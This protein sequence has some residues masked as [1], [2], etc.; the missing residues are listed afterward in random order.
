M[1]EVKAMSKLPPTIA[2][3]ASAPLAT[4]LNS[5]LMFSAAKKPLSCPTKTAQLLMM[6]STEI[7]MVTSFS[8]VPEPRD[9]ADGDCWD[10]TP[11]ET[12]IDKTAAVNINI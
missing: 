1:F 3:A 10:C 6:G 4:R 7:L 12:K 5:S 8:G 11:E 2:E 9:V